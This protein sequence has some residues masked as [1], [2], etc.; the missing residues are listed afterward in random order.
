[1]DI[2]DIQLYVYK[3]NLEKTNI[4]K[5]IRDTKEFIRIFDKEHGN[6]FLIVLKLTNIFMK[7]E[8]LI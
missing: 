4:L 1:M 5:I 8:I 7:M 3:K 2:V 6:F